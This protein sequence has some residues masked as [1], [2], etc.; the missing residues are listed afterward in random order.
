VPCGRAGLKTLGNASHY[1]HVF[2]DYLYS[3]CGSL[4]IQ[5]IAQATQYQ[6]LR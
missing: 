4:E 5:V 1:Y 6:R 3:I 2:S